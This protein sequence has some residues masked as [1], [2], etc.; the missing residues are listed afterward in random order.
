[1][2][3]VGRPKEEN[4]ITRKLSIRLDA[5]TEKILEK[6]CKENNV[7]RAEAIRRGIHLIGEQTKK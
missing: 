5:N 7:S 4:P 3:Q 1:M 6:Y 2:P